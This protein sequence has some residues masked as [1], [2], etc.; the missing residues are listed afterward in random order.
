[1]NTIDFLRLKLTRLHSAFPNTLIKYGFDTDIDR[2]IVEITPREVYEHNDELDECWMSIA[3]EFMESYPYQSISFVS[4]DSILKVERPEFIIYPELDMIYSTRL[5]HTHFTEKDLVPIIEH[6]IQTKVN[7]YF[8][9]GKKAIDS[10]VN[11]YKNNADSYLGV[12]VGNLSSNPQR[13][14]CK[15][16][17][18]TEAE[19][20]GNSESAMAA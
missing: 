13:S 4:D 18:L 12:S 10:I 14:D 7:I 11:I 16:L 15:I 3:R 19:T 8:N 6:I 9:K 20:T 1:M 2:H 5:F 17:Q